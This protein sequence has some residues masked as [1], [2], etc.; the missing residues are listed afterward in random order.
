MKTSTTTLIAFFAA[1]VLLIGTQGCYTQVGTTRD[2]PVYDN[3][4]EAVAGNE[5][6]GEEVEGQA[7]EDAAQY[8][9]D[10]DANTR[11]GFDYYYP[12]TYWPSISFSMAYSDPWYGWY[13]PY[14][15]YGYPYYGYGY[16]YYGYGY[17]YYGYGYGCYYPP[18]YYYAA[19]V[20]ITNRTFGSTRGTGGSGTP[21]GGNVSTGTRNAA[22]AQGVNASSGGTRNNISDPLNMD[23]PSG[24]GRGAVTGGMSGA[25]TSA[26]KA[27]GAKSSTSSRKSGNSRKAI[28][29]RVNKSTR[30]SSTSKD[31]KRIYRDRGAVSG[32]TKGGGS[33]PS[34]SVEPK[35]SNPSAGSSRSGGTRS[36]GN[37]P[38]TRQSSPSGRSSA[39]PPSAAPRSAPPPSSGGASRGG[40]G[41]GGARSPRP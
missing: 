37:T 21:R 9:Q 19:P 30:G 16:P 23:L 41:G 2:E 6:N 8:G 29:D 4:D 11:V 28:S 10:W 36:S 35:R 22:G 40:G 3:D 34:P 7:D 26:G 18:G 25:G 15:S 38:S 20:P 24:S 39:P 32:S 13:D 12:Y 33:N 17:P 31:N 27:T 5:E 14:Y 1:F